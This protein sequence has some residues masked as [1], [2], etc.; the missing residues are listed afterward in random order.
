M[1]LR[2]QSNSSKEP[3]S[4]YMQYVKICKDCLTFSERRLDMST[5]FNV[6]LAL[7]RIADALEKIAD[8][9]CD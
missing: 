8:K 7:A 5:L 4:S 3:L 9:Y 1:E 2:S 6:V